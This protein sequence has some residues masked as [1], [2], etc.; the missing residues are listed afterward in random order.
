[1]SIQE[2]TFD[3]IGSGGATSIEIPTNV[4][5]GVVVCA[6]PTVSHQVFERVQARRQATLNRVA[7]LG[8]EGES[9]WSEVRDCEKFLELYERFA[10][11]AA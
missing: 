9:L 11:G 10:E 4:A 8:V 3:T 6:Q 1:M 7:V 5:H 2:L